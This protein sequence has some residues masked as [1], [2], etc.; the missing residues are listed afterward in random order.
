MAGR[1]RK[2]ATAERLFFTIIRWSQLTSS[3]VLRH[4]WSETLD[5]AN[6][7]PEPAR[8]RSCR[9]ARMINTIVCELEFVRISG[10][11]MLVGYK[12]SPTS[13]M[14]L[15]REFTD[16][17]VRSSN[18]TSASQL[19]LSRVGQPGSIPALVLH[20]GSRAARHRKG[21]TSEGF[22]PLLKPL[23]VSSSGCMAVLLVRNPAE[24][25]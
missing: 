4:R 24:Q 21:T 6:P 20:S 9:T 15:E 12:R 2:G 18:L 19:P 11:V 8:S 17:K 14:W 7:I 25:L 3:V 5:A 13:W 22:F 23:G 1:H 16:R 10:S